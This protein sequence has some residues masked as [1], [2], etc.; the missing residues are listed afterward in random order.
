MRLARFASL[1]LL[2]SLAF[3]R[4]AA[5]VYASEVRA[6]CYIA[7]PN[8]CRVRLAPLTIQTN[9]G[10]RVTLVQV[11]LSSTLAYDFHTDSADFYRPPG[12]Y[13]VPLPSLDLGATCGN[14]YVVSVI[15]RD[16]LD[17]SPYVVAG[18][19]TFTC[20]SGMP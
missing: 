2:A 6:G 14:S 12:P 8:D 4:P 1:A 3:A 11:Y 18:T 9:S 5:A 7:G 17:P 10:G 13:A 19:D 16:T 15:A 20:P